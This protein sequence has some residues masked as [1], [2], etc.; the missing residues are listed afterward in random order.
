[1]RC[2]TPSS[3]ELALAQQGVHKRSLLHVIYGQTPQHQ[4]S[5]NGNPNAVINACKAT[6]DISVLLSTFAAVMRKLSSGALQGISCH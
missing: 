5:T 6:P 4:K 2:R 3:D 1:M